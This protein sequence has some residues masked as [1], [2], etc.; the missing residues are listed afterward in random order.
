MIFSRSFGCLFFSQKL[1]I[2]QQLHV[3]VYNALT[4]FTYH[5]ALCRLSDANFQPISWHQFHLIAPKWNLYQNVGWRFASLRRKS[6]L[7][8]SINDGIIN[9][10]N[11][12]QHAPTHS[13]NWLW[14]IWIIGKNLPW[15]LG[16]GWYYHLFFLNVF[17][18]FMFI[19]SSVCFG[20]P[21]LFCISE[22]IELNQIEL[23]Q[24]NMSFQKNSEIEQS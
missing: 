1:D 8:S 20:C 21:L 13:Y 9:I 2:S 24:T 11:Y 10:D 16:W 19:R 23:L 12:I 4:H 22:R 18:S 14:T 5:V 15:A 3:N 7:V 17:V 6:N